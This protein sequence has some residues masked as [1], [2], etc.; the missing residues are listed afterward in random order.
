MSF[1]LQAHQLETFLDEEFKTRIPLLVL[2]DKS[3]IYKRFRVKQL[4]NQLWQLNFIHGDS[5]ECFNLKASATIAAKC[6][7]QGNFKRYSEIKILDSQYWLS[8]IDAQVFKHRAET[9]K[10]MEKRDIFVA[11]FNL[12]RDRER[13]YRNKITSMFRMT[14]DK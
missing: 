10:D 8:A 13:M 6:Y 1:K 7:D 14:F 11:R 9:T 12:A 5:I 4:K 2:K 3:L